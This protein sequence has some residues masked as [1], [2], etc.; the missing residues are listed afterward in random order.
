VKIALTES[1]G[2]VHWHTA[3]HIQSIEF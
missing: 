3:N 1:D 2:M